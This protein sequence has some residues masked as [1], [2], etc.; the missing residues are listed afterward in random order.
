[1]TLNYDRST[2]SLSNNVGFGGLIH[3]LPHSLS[4]VEATL[5]HHLCQTR[6]SHALRHQTLL[7]PRSCGDEVNIETNAWGTQQKQNKRP[8]KTHVNEIQYRHNTNSQPESLYQEL[9][10]C[11]YDPQC[12]TPVD[13]TFNIKNNGN[14]SSQSS[15]SHF[16]LSQETERLTPQVINGNQELNP[17]STP[18]EHRMHPNL[19]NAKHANNHQTCFHQPNGNK[20]QE[21]YYQNLKNGNSRLSNLTN[22]YTSDSNIEHRMIRKDLETDDVTDIWQR[23]DESPR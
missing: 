16:L 10:T 17:Y 4:A 1:M 20:K 18:G 15:N 21:N 13:P 11:R 22:A 14:I 3:P 5:N 12:Q 7:M 23:S 6:P 9:D 2:P 19:L 8:P